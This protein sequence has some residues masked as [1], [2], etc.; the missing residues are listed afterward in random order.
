[1]NYSIDTHPILKKTN[2]ILVGVVV[3]G[4]PMNFSGDSTADEESW[5]N[6]LSQALDSGQ[7]IKATNS[8]SAS[9]RSLCKS[10]L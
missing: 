6:I 1:V 4:V 5:D 10:Y 2:W 9:A 7:L 8:S 3:N